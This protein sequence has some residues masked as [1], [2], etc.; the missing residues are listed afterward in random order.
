MK[1]NYEALSRIDLDMFYS[2]RITPTEI[3]LQGKQS[4]ETIISVRLNYMKSY[5]DFH[6]NDDGYV[7]GTFVRDG[8]TFRVCLT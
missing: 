2:V 6:I 1:K 8:I 4:S 5:E 7:E 3:N